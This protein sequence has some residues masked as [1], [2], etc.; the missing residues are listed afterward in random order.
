MKRQRGVT[1]SGLIIVLFLLIV[2]A[3]LGF[4]LFTPYS[5]YFTIQKAFKDLSQRTEVKAGTRRD[6]MAAWQPIALIQNITTVSGDDI[7]ITKEG[8]DVIISA[9]YSVKVPLFLNISL[10]IDFNPTS[11]STP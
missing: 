7:E 9:S 1:L 10:L 5:Q 6:V 4:K 8:N 2:G 11:A 3:L